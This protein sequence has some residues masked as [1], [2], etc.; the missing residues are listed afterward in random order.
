MSSTPNCRST[1]ID[2]LNCWPIVAGEAGAKNPHDFYAFYYQQNQLQAVSSGDGRWKLQLP[3]GYRALKPG[4]PPE[5]TG[6]IP[7]L[8]KQ[9]QHRAARTLRPLRRHQRIQ[10]HRQPNTPTK[11]PC[12]KRTPKRS[13]PNS[14]TV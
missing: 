10:K 4:R 14:G 13:A 6:G 7:V 2:G 8:Y 9:R 11:S 3:H 12:S 5:A 1:P